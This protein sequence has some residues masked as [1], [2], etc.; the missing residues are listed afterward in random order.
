MRRNT[1]VPGSSDKPAYEKGFF[2]GK[3]LRMNSPRAKMRGHVPMRNIYK[4]REDTEG[5]DGEGEGGG[6]G[7][8]PRPGAGAGPGAGVGAGAGAVKS[9]KK[10]KSGRPAKSFGPEHAATAAQ[11]AAQGV[12]EAAAGGTPAASGPG[13]PP[14]NFSPESGFDDSLVDPSWVGTSNR[15]P[16]P[17]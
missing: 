15:P 3:K 13:A 11:A 10:S 17:H 4:G 8:G 5:G 7:L 1:L 16:L 2:G 14:H 12:E 9:V 6:A